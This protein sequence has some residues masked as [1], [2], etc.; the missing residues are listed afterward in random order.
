MTVEETGVAARRVA[1][2]GALAACGAG[3]RDA[4]RQVYD[5]TAAKLFGICLRI[6]GERQA[7]ED[8]LQEVYLIIWRRAPAYDAARGSLMSWLCVIARNRALDWRRSRQGHEAETH[9]QDN[10]V[11]LADHADT[12]TL[13]DD[14]MLEAEE[15]D[16]LHQCI[17]DLDERPRAAIRAAFLDGLTYAELARRSAVPLPTMKSV[18]RRALLRLRECMRDDA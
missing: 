13:A 14:A 15:R 1:L 2:I 16:R 11:E 7:A 4:F 10:G 9:K 6:C 8:V 18:I 17:D 3:D 5:T 12:S